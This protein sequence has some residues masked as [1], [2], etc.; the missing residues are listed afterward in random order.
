M[1]TCILEEMPS[2]KPPQARRT[3]RTVVFFAIVFVTGSLT[4]AGLS[5][6]YLQPPP[7]PTASSFHSRGFS[8]GFVNHMRE[9]YELSEEQTE[10]LKTIVREN[11]E[12]VDQINKEFRPKF[13]QAIEQMN[14]KIAAMMS[15]EQQAKFK[16]KLEEMRARWANRKNDPRREGSRSSHSFGGSKSPSKLNTTPNASETAQKNE[17]PE[18]DSSKGSTPKAE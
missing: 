5:A 13:G 16:K 4:G 15:V 11:N 18:S 2:V 6:L 3:L 14:L 1:S 8:E 7:T 9:E 17:Q 12:L 10:K